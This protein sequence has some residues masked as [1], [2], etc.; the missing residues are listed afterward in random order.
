MGVFTWHSNVL[1]EGL[2][3][4]QVYGVAFSDD[5]KILLMIDKGKYNLIGG[6]P[7]PHET[8]YE[9]TLKREFIEEVNIELEDIHYLGYFSV[10]EPGKPEYAQVR[11]IAKIKSIGEKEPD[12]DRGRTYERLLCNQYNVKNYL[13]YGGDGDKMLDDAIKSANKKFSFKSSNDKDVYI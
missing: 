11:M 7:E 6:H 1:P 8:S 10:N 3:V 12:P 4:T 13:N 5:G 2:R 9:Q